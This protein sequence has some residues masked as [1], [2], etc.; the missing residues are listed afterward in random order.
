MAYRIKGIIR[1]S[2]DGDA[3]LGI[4]TATNFI[5]TGVATATEF[6]G[7]VSE[8]AIT[9]QTEGG[10][11][12]VTGA[13][14]LLLYDEATGDLLRV[15]VDEFIGGAGI[16]TI[17]TN[18]N[19]LNVS[20][21]STFGSL[22]SLGGSIVPD[23]NLAY[24]LGT[25]TNR[26]KDL[27]LSGSTIDLGGVELK[28]S[29]GNLEVSGE[30]VVT[31]SAAGSIDLVGIVT[32]VDLDVTG[33][34]TI[35]SAVVGVVTATS[36]FEGNLSGNV[37]GDTTGL[38]NGDV[39]SRDGS[40]IVL[41]VPVSTG[42]AHYI[43]TVT[44]DVTGNLLG[45]V[46]GNVTGQVNG[47]VYTASGSTQVVDTAA[48]PAPLFKG[49]AEGLSGSPNISVNNV[50]AASS[51]TA[52]NYFGDGSALTNILNPLDYFIGFGL[53]KNSYV[54]S[55]NPLALTLSNDGHYYAVGSSQDR[56]NDSLCFLTKFTTFGELVWSKMLDFVRPS[57]G[58]GTETLVA[59]A[60][61]NVVVCGYSNSPI[62]GVTQ[63][64]D[65]NCIWKFSPEGELLWQKSTWA[66]RCNNVAVTSNNDYIF[67]GYTNTG[68]GVVQRYDSLGT[69]VW[70]VSYDVPGEFAVIA[71]VSL[72]SSDNIYVTG[73]ADGE[74]ILLKYNSAGTLIWQGT[75]LSPTKSGFCGNIRVTTDSSGNVYNIGF[76]KRSSEDRNAI[77]SK[78][79][80]ANGT[81]VW[82]TRF[83]YSDNDS[84]DIEFFA[85]CYDS[86]NDAIIAGG[87]LLDGADQNS[88]DGCYIVSVDASTGSVNWKRIVQQDNYQTLSIPQMR[89]T[90]IAADES[91]YYFTSLG[92]DGIVDSD[93]TSNSGNPA[94][95]LINGKLPL[96]GSGIGSYGGYTY[97]EAGVLFFTT[98][99]D[100]VFASSSFSSSALTPV[101]GNLDYV[102]F[103]GDI[104]SIVDYENGPQPVFAAG[105]VGASTV[106]ATSGNFSDL[107]ALTDLKVGSEI[108][109]GGKTRISGI[110][111]I[112]ADEFYGDG[113]GLTG[114]LSTNSDGSVSVGGSIIPTTNIAYDLGSATN[115]FR[116]LYLEG[117]TIFLG[118]TQLSSDTVVTSSADGVITAT[119]FAATTGIITASSFHGDA[120][121]L[122][123]ISA[124]G[125][126]FGLEYDYSTDTSVNGTAAGYFRLN[127][128]GS[129]FGINTTDRNGLSQAAFFSNMRF[130]FRYTVY[131]EYDG[132]AAYLTGVFFNIN[133]SVYKFRNAT[134]RGDLP[135]NDTDCKLMVLPSAGISLKSLDS[136]VT[137]ISSVSTLSGF[138]SSAIA[139][140]SDINSTGVITASSFSTNTGETVEF[141]LD[142]T[143][144]KF[145]V[146]G[147]GSGSVALS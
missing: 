43:G 77:I 111:T 62:D 55:L 108:I 127:G 72:D 110:G 129:Q 47:D 10:I 120:S 27:Y 137:G 146:A 46:S 136:E 20:G 130:G 92:S 57:S 60:D 16:G 28:N 128:S 31:Q 25:P 61:G 17:V 93:N 14:E 48:V 34:A 40:Q 115:R 107:T 38:H 121:Q 68:V 143:T 122:E 114:V 51:V 78:H 33:N 145:N 147:I 131:I 109:G 44:G 104:S 66:G 125:L 37:A 82:G 118:D 87:Y 65:H 138:G 81:A 12:D 45:D 103:A 134:L 42:D 67:V 99:A 59:D 23:T 63:N 113:S 139:V 6:D 29:S 30:V 142:G 19:N 11:G 91:G 21:V 141:I 22:V 9:E 8:K 100:S 5:S 101:G 3:N 117:N 86:V 144:L 123:N 53:R 133:G 94:R 95:V 64:S 41:E 83:E 135:T 106:F 2:D 74:P 76:L 26:F 32:A 36:G 54:R 15:S 80:P 132:G 84:G 73:Y 69:V 13:D 50:S 71:G 96:D 70:S 1:I 85:I 24:D 102:P 112:T 75:Y 18:F 79:N 89:L 105:V 124:S 56:N 140:Q 49:D 97:S 58:E 126:G 7:K 52:V 39:Y 116:T 88:P 98:T 119:G 35:N 90:G 4:V